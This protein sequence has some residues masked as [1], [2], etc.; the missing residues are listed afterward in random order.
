MKKAIALLLAACLTLGTSGMVFAEENDPVTQPETIADVIDSGNPEFQ[1]PE[2]SDEAILYTVESYALPEDFRAPRTATGNWFRNQLETELQKTIYDKMLTYFQDI[3]TSESGISKLEIASDIDGAKGNDGEKALNAVFKDHTELLYWVAKGKGNPYSIAAGSTQSGKTKMFLFL[4]VVTKY[5]GDKAGTDDFPVVGGGTESRDYY[6]I[7]SNKDG[8]TVTAFAK[9]KEIVDAATGTDYEKVKF[10]NQ[11]ICDLTSYD[12]EAAKPDAAYGDTSQMINVFLGKPVVCEGYA[13][14]FKYLCDQT[15]IGC[16]IIEG[17][18]TS[19]NGSKGNHMWNYV[20]L[21]G[22]WYLVDVTN[23]DDPHAREGRLAIGSSN[24]KFNDYSLTF[25]DGT[26][27]TPLNPSVTLSVEDYKPGQTPVEPEKIKLTVTLA[28]AEQLYISIYKADITAAQNYE[29]NYRLNK[30]DIILTNKT[31]K[32]YSPTSEAENNNQN[33]N[34]YFFFDPRLP[35]GDYT[36]TVKPKDG[37]TVTEIENDTFNVKAQL[38]APS[39]AFSAPDTDGNVTVTISMPEGYGNATVSYS[40]NGSNYMNDVPTPAE[41][42]ISATNPD[43]YPTKIVE[44]SAY[45]TDFDSSESVKKSYT[46]TPAADAFQ[47]IVTP[48][49]GLSGTIKYGQKVLM[50]TLST[51]NAKGTVTYEIDTTKCGGFI[52]EGDK[53]YSDH[54][55]DPTDY[56]LYVKATDNGLDSGNPLVAYGSAVIHIAPAGSGGGSI[57]GGSGGGGGG[58]GSSKAVSNGLSN[59]STATVST[60]TAKKETEKSVKAAIAAALKSNQK[61]A[62]ATITVK[63]TKAVS[64]ATLKAIVESAQNAAKGK[65]VAITTILQSDVV[66][67]GKVES[68]LSIDPA[69]ATLTTDLKLGVKLEN[70][71]VSSMFS[72]YF[73]NKTA[74]VAFEQSGTFGMPIEVAA[75]LDLSKLDTKTL[76]FYTYDAKTNVYAEMTAP[77]YWIDSAGYLHFTTTIGN[78]VVITDKPLTRK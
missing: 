78:N 69:K 31:G 59:G 77:A 67:N 24:T 2:V 44:A 40:I 28:S 27:T 58:G 39:I 35:A 62:T 23:N 21:D 71:A 18:L 75:K 13:K 36:I 19:G 33:G 47:V 70:K 6:N 3:H 16:F 32:T 50:A 72:K 22:K 73:T 45:H 41:F 48:V 49:T 37:F 74:I 46:F 12:D 63:N 15:G 65:G 7:L 61:A 56:T 55:F 1:S 52:I 29:G 8:D 34:C 57:G 76:K 42:T 66:K 53:V 26:G 51:K 20:E 38:P 60:A 10:F 54:Q 43:A 9:A 68:R 17:T 11:K 25:I 5:K 14:A 64:A 30:A 4:S